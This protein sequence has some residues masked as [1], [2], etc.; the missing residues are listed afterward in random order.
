MKELV[1]LL[2]QQ[3][4]IMC[5]TGK[6]FRSSVSGHQVWNMYLGSFRPEDNPIFRDPNS[7]S[8]NCNLCNNFIRRYGNIVSITD[9][10]YIKSIFSDIPYS[11]DTTEYHNSIQNCATLLESNLI[12]NVF[13]ETYDE[14]NSLPYE[15]CNKSQPMF[16]LGLNVNY[17][18]YTQEEAAKY[19]A[20]TPGIVYTFNHFN[21]K[22]PTL[23]VDKSGKSIESIMGNYRDKYSVFKRAMEEIPLDTLLLVRDLIN[24][25]SLLDGTSHLH[26]INEYITFHSYK[27]M[28]RV[29]NW[30]WIMTYAMPESI[31]K[32]KNHAIGKLCS[33]LAEGKELNDA[34]LMWNKMVDPVNYHKAKTPITQAQIEL[35][36]R[37]V[38]ENG[39]VESF[40]RRL[41]TLDDIKASEILHINRDNNKTKPVSIFDNIKTPSGTGRHKRSEFDKVEEVSIDKFMQDILPVCTSVELFLENRM[42]GN[43]VNLTTA[44]ETSKQIFKWGNPFSYTFNGNLAG[45]S[46]LTQM[47]EVKGG[48]IDGVLRC[49]HS[50]N[51]LEANQ[52]LMDAHLFFPG[53]NHTTGKHDYYGSGRRIGWNLRT[54]IS[55]KGTQDVDY[56]GEA[57]IGFIPIENITCPS[58]NNMP[59][60]DY[61]YKIHNWN[62]RKSGGRGECEIA[63]EGNL[64][65]YEYPATQHKEWIDVAKITLKNGRFTI[66]HILPLKNEA[67]KEVWGLNTNEFHKVALVCPTPNHWGENNIGNKHYLFMLQGCANPNSVRGFHNEHLISDL[68]QHRK[69]LDVLANTCMIEST[70]N[71]I[72]GVGF[73]ATVRDEVILKLQG[74]HKRI[75]KLKI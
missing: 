61:Y 29:D 40:N 35:A 2:Q 75:V 44:A 39:Y 49:T 52:S 30:F 11:S 21:L 17:K 55:S 45:K 12:A 65:Q 58:L 3:F 46:Q 63:F 53:N 41:A 27:P 5:Q 56:I 8:H 25:G 62:F 7:S 6:L 24:Q 51:R 14:L 64:Y 57:P 50:W 67:S 60:G 59:E 32:F 37:F 10:G 13:F 48:R 73:N 19:G 66:T 33:D 23:F 28:V 69:V 42:E 18:E 38:E 74:S 47:V 20:V 9:D 71:Q 16:Q 26:V 22:L 68:L 36:K 72:A 54:D 4:D 15:K 70:P 34:V 31:A 1:L 43:L